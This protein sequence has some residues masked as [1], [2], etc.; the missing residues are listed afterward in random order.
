[1]KTKHPSDKLTRWAESVAELDIAIV[2][3]PGYKNSN[4]DA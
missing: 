1:M 2:Y 3:R 4:A